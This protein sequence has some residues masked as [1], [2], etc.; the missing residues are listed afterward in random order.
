MRRLWFT[1]LLVMSLAISV[2][3][4][5]WAA[6]DCPFKEAPAAAAAHDCCPDQ[7]PTPDPSE[8]H[9]KSMDCQLGQSCRASHAVEPL[10]PVLMVAHVE[11]IRAI[12]PRDQ[13]D[14]PSSVASGLWRPPRVI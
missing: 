10:V 5:A 1:V 3:A 2:T 9:G 11:V 14:A 4:S 12:A 13:Q 6:Q 8:H 7:E